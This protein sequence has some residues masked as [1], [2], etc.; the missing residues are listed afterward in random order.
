MKKHLLFLLLSLSCLACSE[1]DASPEIR[2]KSLYLDSE[3]KVMSEDDNTQKN[4]ANNPDEL[5]ALKAGDGLTILLSLDGNGADLKSFQMKKHGSLDTKLLF[6]SEEV[7]NE[8]NLS[9]P[10]DG[11]IRFSDGVKKTDLMV[12]AKVIAIDDNGDAKLS[13]YLSSK[14]E[15]NGAQEEMALKTEVSKK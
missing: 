4:Y 9:K 13:F 8:E 7:S 2:V 15:C 12:K 3:A 11:Q 1:N 6:Q 10:E 5:P 14:A